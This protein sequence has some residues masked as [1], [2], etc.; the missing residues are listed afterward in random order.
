MFIVFNRR[1][2][3]NS[4]IQHDKYFQFKILV[5]VFRSGWHLWYLCKISSCYKHLLSQFWWQ[6][7]LRFTAL[8]F[9]DGDSYSYFPCKCDITREF[10]NT[11]IIYPKS[12]NSSWIVTEICWFDLMLLEIR[13][14]CNPWLLT[15]NRRMGRVSLKGT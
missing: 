1:V 14:A 3:L 11:S 5:I 15:S 6:R 2:S 13:S 8:K 12:S 10:G 4:K 7:I 9:F